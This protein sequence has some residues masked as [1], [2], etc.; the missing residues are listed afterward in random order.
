MIQKL[1]IANRGEIAAR[2]M[3]TAHALGIATVAVFSDPDADAPFVALADEAVRLPGAAPADTYLRT[4]LIISAARAAGADAVHPGYG[5]LSEN[6][7]FAR[8]CADAGLIFVGPPPEA[9]AAMGSKLEAKALM[10]AAGVPVLPGATVTEETDLAAVAARIGFPLLVK[11]AF[12]GGGRGMRVVRG[13]ADLADAVEGAR[14]EAA[15]AFG[16]GTVFLERFVVDPRHVEVQIFGDAHGSVVH[17][18]ERECSIQRRYQKIV[19]EAPSPAVDDALRAELGAAAVA[20]GK[21]IGY[22]GAGTVEFVLTDSGE[23]FFLEVNT[24]LQV[25]HP[26]TELVTGLDLVELQLRVAEG[27]PLPPAVLDAR[28]DGHAIEVR[29][30]A[31]DVPAGFLPATGTLHR[32]AV[33]PGPGVRVD[34]GVV[35]GSVVGTH[36]DPMLA[37]VI[38][39]GA[40]RADAAR[41]LA[42]ALQQARIHGVTTNRDLLAGI[43]REQ[44]FLAGRTD[45]GY[46]ARHDP[47]ALG[48]PPGDAVAALAAAAALAGQAGNRAAA[49]VLATL[50]SGWRNVGGAP[51]RVSY[52]LGGRAVEVAYRYTRDGVTVTVDGEP[53]TGVRVLAAAPTEVDLEIGGV[54]RTFFVHRAGDTSYV[55]SPIGSAALVTV[56]R[57]ADP[58]AAQ[59]AGSLLAPMPGGVVRVLA[60]PGDT[61]AAG[62]PLIVLE[63]MKMEHTITAPADGTVTEVHV[64]RGDQVDTGQV[65]AVVE[66]TEEA[67]A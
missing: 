27:E 33:P 36:Y 49:T 41:R 40:T 20:A 38:A 44:E 54:R 60:E 55:D 2:V 47:A 57:F 35:D 16:D 12:G 15:S 11:A 23:F 62:R 58:S 9:I 1:L 52:T 31:E 6:A 42:R 30:Y 22:V 43:L 66:A 39:H 67:G 5:F 24:R 29:L 26:V 32:F 64:V 51:Q 61:V 18:F 48:A 28:I 14:R 25:E 21:A 59:H 8:A 45:T 13:P 56:P 17:L 34:A 4:D 10:E 65:L 46:L 3:R 37:K 50:P 63:A 7:G 19:E 53:L